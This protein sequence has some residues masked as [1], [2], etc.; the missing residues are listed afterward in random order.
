MQKDFVVGGHVRG[1][2]VRGDRVTRLYYVTN[3]NHSA[4]LQNAV[5]LNECSLLL[6]L[7]SIAIVESE[8]EGI[9]ISWRLPRWWITPV[10]AQIVAKWKTR[11]TRR[12]RTMHMLQ[13]GTC[14]PVE[15]ILGRE[16]ENLQIW[17]HMS[18]KFIFPF[19]V[20]FSL[21]FLCIFGTFMF[22]VCPCFVLY[23]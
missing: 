18:E 12:T 1:D 2:R 4:H 5:L 13:D 8:C 17:L 6:L 22:P 7:Q 23:N 15:T 16:R 21:Q 19:C 9:A 11:R 3:I 10:W 20:F 14:L